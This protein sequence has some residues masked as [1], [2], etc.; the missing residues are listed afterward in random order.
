[1]QTRSTCARM[2]WR[3]LL[4]LGVIDID[5]PR[6]PGILS[7]SGVVSEL[8]RFGIGDCQQRLQEHIGAI[9]GYCLEMHY[10]SCGIKQSAPYLEFKATLDKLGA[11]L[12]HLDHNAGLRLN[13]GEF[14]ELSISS[15]F[16]ES[17]MKLR[18]DDAQVALMDLRR[19]G[20]EAEKWTG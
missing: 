2:L 9:L 12:L 1:M 15:R 16:L 5:D 18:Y 10:G 8:L 3:R 7:T 14:I 19:L 13:N 6:L 4:E 20:S 11:R 17:Y